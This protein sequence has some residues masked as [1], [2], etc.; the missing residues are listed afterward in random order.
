MNLHDTRQKSAPLSTMK[1]GHLPMLP[2][3]L[4]VAL[5]I[6]LVFS[7]NLLRAQPEP[8]FTGIV[9]QG[10]AASLTWTGGAGP[11]LVQKKVS[12]SD[13]SWVNVITVSNR[14]L[15]LT[16]E[17]ESGFL[18]LL[19]QTTN[20]VLAFSALLR[21]DNEVPAV[22][23]S[24]ATGIGAFSLE[25]SNLNYYVSFSGLISPATA[26][27]FHAPATP[28]NSVGVMVAIPPPNVTSGIISGKLGLTLAQ[29]SNIVNGLSYVNVHTTSNAP[30]E[31]RG[32]VVPLR[33][34]VTMNGA[35]EETPTGSS[36]IGRG[37]LTFIGNR[38][39][40]EIQYS[41][42]SSNAIAAHIHGPASTT[43]SAGVLVGLNTPSGTEG[44]ISGSLTLTPQELAFILAGKTYINLHTEA[45]QGGE[46]RGQIWPTQFGAT[47]NGAAEVPAVVTDATGSAILNVVSNVVNYTVTYTNLSSA[48]FAAHIHGPSDTAH[49]AGVLIGLSGVPATTSGTFSGSFTA[50]TQ[51][52]FYILSGLTYVNIHTANH[53]DGEIRGQLY[54]A[55]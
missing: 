39:F 1:Q 2:R 18:R 52:L 38:L 12:L 47:L 37:V 30:G 34:V 24:P 50:T 21:P 17:A 54:P 48:P 33:M 53:N 55:Y 42:L 26:A 36:G 49:G 3:L 28:T 10:I 15:I 19:S 5:T 40:Y 23:N 8:G 13:T 7:N 32:Q 25:G 11:F 43:N 35:S 4:G 41:G 22:T 29:I 31:I 9:D 46:I 44:T 51:D 27:H 16:K 14:S 6:F 20:T 45:H